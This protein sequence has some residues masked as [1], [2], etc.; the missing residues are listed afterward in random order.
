M[1]ILDWIEGF[2]IIVTV[3]IVILVGSVNNYSKESEF[4]DLKSKNEKEKFIS[5]KRSGQQINISVE[6]VLVG[7]IMMIIEGMALA[8]DGILLEGNNITTDESAMTGETDMI[9]KD[10]YDICIVDR[11]KIYKEN[12]GLRDKI[13]EN[14]HHKIKSPIL[15]SGTQ[16]A[17]GSGIMVVIAV[18]PNSQSGKILTMIEANKQND[19]G[20][21]LQQKLTYIADFVGY[22]GLGAS[23]LTMIGMSINL[24]IRAAN[25]TAGK[26]GPEIMQI[27]LIGVTFHLF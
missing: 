27:F 16:I 5:V 1:F 26:A 11:D 2:A 7:D 23:V 21:P 20:T 8:A 18:G 10:V 15:S 13:P 12:P 3:L 24:A 25:K 22:C 6:K 9:E 14:Y 17:S 4:R 19:E